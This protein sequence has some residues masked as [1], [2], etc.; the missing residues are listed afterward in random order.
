MPIVEIK[1]RTRIVVGYRAY[2]VCR[3]GLR[4]NRRAIDLHDRNIEHI[5]VAVTEIKVRNTIQQQKRVIIFVRKIE[6][7]LQK[8]TANA[9]FTIIWSSYNRGDTTGR[10][11]RSSHT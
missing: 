6:R 9:L 7:I 3:S 1:Q 10:D 8:E 4:E 11:T 2:L 5:G